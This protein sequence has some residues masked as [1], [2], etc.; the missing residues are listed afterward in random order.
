MDRKINANLVETWRSQPLREEQLDSLAEGGPST[1]GS[2]FEPVCWSDLLVGDLVF[3]REGCTFPADILLLQSSAEQGIANI[4]TANLDGE[5][6]LKIKQAP[7]ECWR[8]PIGGGEKLPSSSGAGN[9]GGGGGGGGGNG[10]NAVTAMAA[11][12]AAAAAAAVN[13]TLRLR[14]SHGN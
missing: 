5:I 12:A 3:V 2:G 8:I 10:N 6:N 7:P 1:A 9:S 11:A 4:E 14:C 13:T